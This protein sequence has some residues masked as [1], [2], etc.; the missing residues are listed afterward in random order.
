NHILL[1]LCRKR[2][3][4]VVL[5][6]VDG[7]I[8]AD[9]P[10]GAGTDGGGFNP[11]T[12]EAF[13]SQRDGTL[14]IIKENSTTTFAVEQTVQTKPGAKTCTLDT[15]NNHIILIATERAPAAEDSAPPVAAA[16]QPGGGR[17]G[18]PNLLDIVVVG[19]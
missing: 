12:M 11:R 1:A 3:P 8:L 19:Q 16:G 9:L 13:S 15:K 6:A 7:R 10:I 18:G 14:T 4:C 17:R 2:P 5:H